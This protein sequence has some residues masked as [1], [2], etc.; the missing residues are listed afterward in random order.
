MDA[1]ICE[2]HDTERDSKGICGQCESD[3][4][5]DLKTLA[6]QLPFLRL[7]A[8]R[9]TKIMASSRSRGRKSVAP[10]PLNMPAFQLQEDIGRFARQS[11]IAL[12]L[13]F[14]KK[15]CTEALL[16][17]IAGHA[18][19]I[20]AIDPDT[21]PRARGLVCRLVVMVEPP[22]ARRLI[23]CCAGCL[24]DL[25][26]SDEVIRSGSVVCGCGMVNVVR[27][28]QERLLLR[29]ALADSVVSGGGEV[30]ARGT[31]A[32][33]SRLLGVNGIVVRRKTISEWYR[34]GLLRSVG[35]DGGRPVF[36]VWD[37]WLVL[38]RFRE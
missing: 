11:A 21:G 18:C 14:G 9:K 19:R 30:H 23:G 33:V 4:A 3:L 28:V 5:D 22:S 24:V 7:I 6:S 37:V 13:R 34:R 31:A 1:R 10:I 36:R 15:T 35:V 26:V 16:K 17:G 32:E 27:E 25:W 12:G 38:N 29:C 2:R 20:L 8:A